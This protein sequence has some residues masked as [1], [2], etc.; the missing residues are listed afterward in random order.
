MGKKMKR[1]NLTIDSDLYEKARTVA[2]IKRRSI[3]EIMRIA[4]GEWIKKN[5]DKKS[6]IILSA[7]DEAKLLKILESDEFISKEK[8]KK[9]LDL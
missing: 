5:M 9:I 1:I 8:A 7:K 6:E 4:L 3:S 2:F